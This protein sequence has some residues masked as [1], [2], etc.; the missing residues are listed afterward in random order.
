MGGAAATMLSGG[1]TGVGSQN[2]LTDQEKVAVTKMLKEKY[3]ELTTGKGGDGDGDGQR[4]PPAD[5]EIYSELSKLYESESN[6]ILA[7]RQQVTPR[8]QNRA[9]QLLKQ[10]SNNYLGDTPAPPS[11]FAFD[12]SA[13]T[14]KYQPIIEDSPLPDGIPYDTNEKLIEALKESEASLDG[15]DKIQLYLDK[16][17]NG[18]VKTQKASKFRKKR[19]TY[20]HNEKPAASLAASPVAMPP[21]VTE[22]KA[23]MGH[24]K[25][26]VSAAMFKADEIG[27]LQDG[28]VPP[29]FPPA[30][31]GVFSCHGVEPGENE[32]GEEV[33][34]DKINQDRG[35]VVNPYRGMSDESL[36]IVLDGHG[37]QGD[38]ISEFAM[39]QIAI[40]LEK[41]PALETDPVTAL[42]ETFVNTNTALMV[43][44]MNFM[45]S[46]STCVA[47]YQKGP[48]LYVAN[49]GDSRAVAAI[50]APA[51]A[52]AAKDLSRDHKPDDPIE[53]ARITAAGGF[54]KPPPREGLSARVYLDPAMTMIGL[55]MARSIGDYTVKVR[56]WP[57]WK[58]PC[59]QAS[60]HIQ[61]HQPPRRP[62]SAWG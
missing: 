21:K 24:R 19:L 49:C 61:A 55:A 31:L 27:A 43:T 36:F 47:V 6:K 22:I 26:S 13:H 12:V 34:N 56:L 42:K 8:L 28:K 3:A 51:A 41:H 58:C 17:L 39:R 30:T 37:S 11:T 4:A 20:E 5:I 59:P 29:P 2:E 25:V 60:P 54:V 50:A 23:A 18:E 53:H 32:D 14:L 15:A 40:S 46:G 45:T 7:S 35:C 16:L 44:P 33:V 57:V 62:S 1:G 9:F 52:V 48:T 38:R 10:K